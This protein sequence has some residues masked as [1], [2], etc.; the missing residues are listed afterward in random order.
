MPRRTGDFP[1]G[2]Y[3]VCLIDLLGQKEKLAEWAKIPAASQPPKEFDDAVNQTAGTVLRFKQ[4]FLNY[5]DHPA[6][7]GSPPMDLV[8]DD[9]RPD[10]LALCERCKSSRVSVQQFADTFVFYAPMLNSYGDVTSAP[11]VQMMGACCS[12][13]ADSL[14][15]GVPLRGA[16]C[17]GAGMEL[18]EANFYGPA[19]AEA[20]RLESDIA[21]RPRI[22]VSP[23]AFQFAQT[24]SNFSEDRRVNS[25]MRNMAQECLCLMWT[26]DDG[27]VVADFLGKG[28]RKLT[29]QPTPKTLDDIAKAYRFACVEGSR[30][31][32]KAIEDGKPECLRNAGRYALLRQYIESRL[33]I[34]GLGTLLEASDGA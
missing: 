30:F 4:K 29:G 15:N 14:A 24:Y 31:K 10:F 16:L 9:K 26:D 18:G 11:F 22:V 5:F 17:I 28:M 8:P 12:A 34:W 1:L 20:H 3:V 2:Y 27:N 33:P 6:W 7:T 25:T 21:R 23:G 32:E 13:M 19:L